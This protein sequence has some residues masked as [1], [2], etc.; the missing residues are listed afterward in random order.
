MLTQTRG[1]GSLYQLLLFLLLAMPLAAQ[2]WP[3]P[4]VADDDDPSLLET[5]KELNRDY[6][7]GKLP[8]ANVTVSWDGTIETLGELAATYFTNYEGEGEQI[9]IL[10]SPRFQDCKPC[11][12][13]VIAHEA[14]HVLLGEKSFG[15]GKAFQKAMRH[16]VKLGFFDHRW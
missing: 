15:H 14:V 16:L 8:E 9:H 12:E 4:H 2:R 10:I 1:C 11:V 13:T 3:V 5:Y 6:F 7:G